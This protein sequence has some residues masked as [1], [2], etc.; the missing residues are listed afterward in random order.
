MLTDTQCKQAKPKDK[1]YKL[2]DER[3]TGLYLAI[4]PTGSKVWRM[5]FRYHQ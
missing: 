4:L 5:K 1:L 3:G 2:F